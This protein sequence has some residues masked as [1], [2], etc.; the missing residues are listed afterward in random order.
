MAYRARLYPE[1]RH[2]I[3]I[4]LVR[5]GR[6]VLVAMPFEVL[7]EIGLRIKHAFPHA[8]VVSVA[9]GYE[10]YLPLAYEYERGG[11]E[12]TAE[13]THFEIGTADRLLQRVLTELA[14]F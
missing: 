7:S 14:S 10:G 1:D 12:S 6:S 2:R 3:Q 5:L 11:Y 8:V 13:T 4:Q 9:N